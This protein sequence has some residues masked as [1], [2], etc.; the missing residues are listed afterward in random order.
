[1]GKCELCGKEGSRVQVNHKEH[2]KI[3]VC[4]SCWSE[5]YDKGQ[6]ICERTSSGFSDSGGGCPSCM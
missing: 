3:M 6:K 1:M 2:G 4:R 5:I